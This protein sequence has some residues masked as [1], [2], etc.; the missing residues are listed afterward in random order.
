MR[1]KKSE[2]KDLPEWAMIP[3]LIGGFFGFYYA[4]KIAEFLINI[5]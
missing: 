3:I 5:F 2:S 4:G 1:L